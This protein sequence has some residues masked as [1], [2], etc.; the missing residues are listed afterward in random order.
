MPMSVVDLLE[1]I[2]IDEDDGELVVV[3]LRPVN[4]RLQ[5]E[6]HMPR[7]VEGRAVI[8]DRQLVDAL[9]VTG[10]FQSD[11][12][13]VGK[14]FEELQVAGIKSLRPHAVD[15]LDDAKTGITKLDRDRDNRLSLRF[16]FF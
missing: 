11:G 4:L 2:E 1:M 15:Q 16:G 13:K 6:T 10:V 3:A 9:D 14:R 8:R 12:G 7:V 5:N